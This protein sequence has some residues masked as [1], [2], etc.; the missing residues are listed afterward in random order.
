MVVV[1]GPQ[2]GRISIG[3]GKL[4][5]KRTTHTVTR[6]A[7]V[8][9]IP[10]L[11][12]PPSE[13]RLRNMIGKSHHDRDLFVGNMFRDI[14][15]LTPFE[16][17]APQQPH[18]TTTRWY[19]DSSFGIISHS[20][21]RYHHLSLSLNTLH[22]GVPRSWTSRHMNRRPNKGYR[23]NTTDNLGWLVLQGGSASPIWPL[24]HLWHPRTP[25]PPAAACPLAGPPLFPSRC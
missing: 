16:E 24:L 5:N 20:L 7:C 12:P 23:S 8:N 11:Y 10:L 15:S 17:G 3:G 18:T 9:V 6:A 19:D 13:P 14:V 4:N 22:S 21:P 2:K 25:A 1:R